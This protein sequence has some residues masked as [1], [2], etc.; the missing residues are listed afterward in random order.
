MIFYPLAIDHLIQQVGGVE[1]CLKKSQR[2]NL[3]AECDPA[4]GSDTAE[5]ELDCDDEYRKNKLIPKQAT[6]RCQ[7]PHHNDDSVRNNRSLGVVWIRAA[8]NDGKPE[9]WKGEDEVERSTDWETRGIPGLDSRLLNR[10]EG[11]H[12]TAS[13]HHM[14]KKLLSLN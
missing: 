3:H 1:T 2:C 5:D 9:C 4:E 7:S 11:N 6:F 12:E 13:Y 14:T 10:I 8:L